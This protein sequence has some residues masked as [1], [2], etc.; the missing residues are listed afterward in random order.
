MHCLKSEN[1]KPPNKPRDCACY[2]Y[3]SI[4]G[5]KV[6]LQAR[7]K[8][9][10]RR[11][12][13]PLLGGRGADGSSGALGMRAHPLGSDDDDDDNDDDR[14]AAHRGQGLSQ[15]LVQGLGFGSGASGSGG[16]AGPLH[17]SGP[18]PEGAGPAGGG[19]GPRA[20]PSPGARASPAPD[21]APQPALGLFAGLG[22]HDGAGPEPGARLGAVVHARGRGEDWLGE[23][24]GSQEVP[25]QGLGLDEG[26]GLVNPAPA[27]GHDVEAPRPQRGGYVPPPSPPPPPQPP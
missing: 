19:A 22:L 4:H 17:A 18:G 3:C 1:H 12:L 11:F 13:K 9:L 26:L 8:A 6:C 23:Q 25:L 24:Q 15:G 27:L 2:C 5:A 14:G 7:W 16:A 21:P 10:D 20:E